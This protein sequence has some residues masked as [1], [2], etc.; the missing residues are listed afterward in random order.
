ML[1][2]Q[3]H[4]HRDVGGSSACR[5]T[6]VERLSGI[7]VELEV[8]GVDLIVACSR[9]GCVGVGHVRGEHGTSANTQLLR[10]EST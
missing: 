9:I 7:V 2:L 10:L 6:N 3:R 8:V 4:M 5:A 1:V